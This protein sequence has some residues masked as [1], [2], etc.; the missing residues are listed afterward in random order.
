MAV[1]AHHPAFAARDQQHL[2]VRLEAHHAVDDLGADRLQPLGVVDVGLFVEARLELHHRGHF[3][4]APNGLAQQ[5][6]HLGLAAGA[7]DGLL[8]RQH[9]GVVDRLAQ[10]RQHRIEALVGLVDQHVALLH[11]FEEGLARLQ[12]DRPA[13]RV[14]IEP[15]RGVVHLVDQ[16]VQPHQVH[17]PRHAEQRLRRQGELLQQEAREEL[18]TAGRDFQPQRLAVVAMLQADAQGGAQVLDLFLVDGQVGVAGDA[19]LRELGHLPAGKQVGQVGADQAGDRDEGVLLRPLG[20]GHAHEARQDAWHLDD[21]HLVF[22]AEGVAALEAHDEVERLVGHLRKRVRRVQP[23]GHQQGLHLALEE[24]LDPAP[25]GGVALAVRDQLDALLLQQRQHLV[26]VDRVLLGHQLVQLGA[27]AHIAV[28]RLRAALFVGIEGGQLGRHAHLEELV[29]VA[30]DD[31]QVAQALQ[32][33]HLFAPRPVQH[34]FVEGQ[35]AVVP[36][37]KGQAGVGGIHR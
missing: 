21:G 27:Q 9:V 33:R 10:E 24:R 7:V 30:G 29:E 4:A 35:D 11:P 12:L 28:R 32:Q 1:V 17:R 8:D 34:A 15:Q 16:L 37:E 14:P 18:G 36:V 5:L 19:E 3:L 26:V 20:P 25:L 6:D 13:R 2:G 22:A 31:A 23:D